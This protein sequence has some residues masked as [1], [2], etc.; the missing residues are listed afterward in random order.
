[1]CGLIGYVGDRQSA[2][3]LVSA[4]K[5]LEYRGYDSCGIAVTLNGTMHLLRYA[6]RIGGLEEKVATLGQALAAGHCGIGHTR[7]ATHGRPTEANAH[8]HADCTGRV[9]VAHN[10]IIE[11]YVELRRR[12]IAEGH[13]F[14]SETDSEVLAHLIE[15]RLNGKLEDA[16][17]GAIAEIEGVF[18]LV[19]IATTEPSK[20]VAVRRGLPLVVGLGEHE[21]IVASDVPA[22]LPYTRDV[23]FLADGEIVVLRADHVELQDAAAR[24][25]ECRRQHLE[26]TAEMAEKE[27]Y[28]HFM[29]KEILEQPRALRDTL[30]GR[31]RGDRV[32]LEDDLCSRLNGALTQRLRKAPRLQILACGTSLHAGLIGKL[33]IESL[34][35]M[36]VDVDYASEFRYRNPVMGKNSLVL[37]ISQS[38]ETA[39]T[40]AGLREARDHGAVV[41]SICNV[42]GSSIARE[43]DAVLYTH[44][45]PEI[46]VASTKAF[47]TQVALLFALGVYLGGLRGALSRQQIAEHV[48]GLDRLSE[49]MERFLAT[50]KAI[51]PL[52][53]RFHDHASFLFLGRGISYP[54]ALEGAL[55][56]KEISYAHA[57]GYPAGEMKHGPIA[58]IDAQMPVVVVAP[59]DH[60]Y[61]KTMGNVEEAKGRDGKVIAIATEGDNEV[62]EK[63]DETIFVAPTHPLLSPLLTVLPL[64][65]LAYHIGVRRGC[66]VDKPRNLAKSVTVE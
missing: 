50:R 46:G 21:M 12:L 5:R 47:T 32:V 22:I 14:H 39:D 23:H 33:M 6:G 26:W 2:P 10:G 28:P 66:D 64:Q 51:E 40:L 53:E 27:G 8:P 15:A 13:I 41:L 65:L 44:A 54:I 60:V 9:L 52:C 34:A 4:L 11:N 1:M 37:G 58:L 48:A 3:V 59:Q 25:I 24:T 43:S 7:W 42:V 63:A 31:V 30:C 62:Q 57:E 55:K 19:V 56:L 17:R 20:I 61:R 38:G 18:G 49:D 29:L 36:P 16:V 35:R 45:G